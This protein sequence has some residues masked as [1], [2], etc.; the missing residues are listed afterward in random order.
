VGPLGKEGI[1]AEHPTLKVKYS[2]PEMAKSAMEL[3]T[4]LE[5][6]RRKEKSEQEKGQSVST[7]EEV[8]VFR[9][10]VEQH[11]HKEH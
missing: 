3:R 7:R 4:A 2:D 8:E 11:H 10:H 9:S 5:E 6:E 1:I